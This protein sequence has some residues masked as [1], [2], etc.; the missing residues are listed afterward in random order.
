MNRSGTTQS[1]FTLI[2][3]L[4]VISIIGIIAAMVLGLAGLAAKK[5]RDAVA[6]ATVNRL[7]LMIEN[8][9]DK[10]G[11][12]PP[13]NLGNTTNS[14]YEQTTAMN[15]LLYELTGST[16]NGTT[17][18]TFDGSPALTPSVLGNVYGRAGIA[19]SNPDEPHNFY[20]PPP[21]TSDYAVYPSGG[22]GLEG[23]IVT[24]A[25]T[26]TAA[27]NFVHYDSSSTNRHNPLT[28]DVWV[29]YSVGN[30][31]NG[32]PLIFTVGNWQ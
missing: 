16:Y 27:P 20:Y 4:V 13:D 5:K 12:Y 15:Q 3:L 30:D 23:L 2:E 18:Q 6:S 10:L 19:N 24:V 7:V 28:F 25:G 1:G 8:Y 9:H 11:F 22:S 21:K 32:N 17:Y 31:T 26:N 29:E 14:L